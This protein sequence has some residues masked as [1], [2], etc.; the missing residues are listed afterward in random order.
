MFYLP[1]GFHENWIKIFFVL[2]NVYKNSIVKSNPWKFFL[3]IYQKTE[4]KGEIPPNYKS[5]KPP[6]RHSR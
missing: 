2:T 3:R 1:S 6:G 4:E 5:S